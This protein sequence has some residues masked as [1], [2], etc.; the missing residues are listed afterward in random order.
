V[1]GKLAAIR[2]F[3][4]GRVAVIGSG[5]SGMG[6][7]YLLAPYH[8]VVMYEQ[9]ERIGGHTRTVDIQ[10]DGVPVAVDTGFIVFNHRN[11]PHLTRLFARL[12]V[13]TIP[14]VMSFG[15]SINDGEL[16]YSGANFSGLFGQKRNLFRPRFY[17]MVA[18]ILRFNKQALTILDQQDHETLGAFLERGGYSQAFI[19]HYLLPM[20]G[21]I[22]SCP[23]AE[24]MQF[25]AR[26]FVQFFAN[27]GLLT[28]QD[29]PQWYTVKG[30]S[31]HYVKKITAR[32]ASDMR[33][34]T[35][36][37]G[38]LRQG[39]AVVVR[40]A[41]GGEERFEK[42]F[43][44]CHG[45]Q[46]LS[47]LMDANE[48]EKQVFGAFRGQQNVAYLH[49]DTRFMP[50]RRACWASWVYRSQIA[51]DSAEVEKRISLSYWMNSLQTLPH[52]R[53]LFVTLNPEVQP[54]PELTFDKH[55]FWHP[56]F[57]QD[58]LAAQSQIPSVQGRGGVYFVGAYQRY[59]FHEDGLLSAV[60]V[61]E[62]LSI[63]VPWAV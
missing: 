23:V 22:W 45:H 48:Q 12:G 37:T 57:T 20:G 54:D 33:L 51:P 42:V 10:Y 11:Y 49:R 32:Y 59:G 50:K 24:M 28:V 62:K 13:E 46:V 5:I 2:G 25:P 38:V 4:G 18:D 53:P 6:M 26:M 7:A 36:V 16:E 19:H 34:N 27:H 52:D 55:V 1:A 3:M 43:L 56:I 14:S 8:Q 40:D 35:R 29:Q 58:S 30:G 61:A 9:A 31:K 44:A 15:V 39:D 17:R 41:N 60:Q 47:L 21:S 63:P